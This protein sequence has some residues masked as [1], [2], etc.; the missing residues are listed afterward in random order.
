ML[1]AGERGYRWVVGGA[2]S[3]QGGSDF[4]VPL[5]LSHGTTA[6]T[7]HIIRHSFSITVV[8]SI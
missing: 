6:N 8:A 5:G 1:D 3:D 7:K 4:V 2:G